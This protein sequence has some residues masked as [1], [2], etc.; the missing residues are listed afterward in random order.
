MALVLRGLRL[1]SLLPSYSEGTGS[2]HTLPCSPGN[3]LGSSSFSWALDP[4]RELSEG[5]LLPVAPHD[6]RGT[7]VGPSPQTKLPALAGHAGSP[8]GVEVHCLAQGPEPHRQVTQWPEPS[9]PPGRHRPVASSADMPHCCPRPAAALTGLSAH[10]QAAASQWPEGPV[11]PEN[12]V[13]LRGHT[14]APV[15]SP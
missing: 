15:S 2:A 12:H 5:L 8:L 7:L 1:L 13:L 10:S 9:F 14:W 6:L 4:S 3:T 11:A